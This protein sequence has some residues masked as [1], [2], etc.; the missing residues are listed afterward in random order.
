[1]KTEVTMLPNTSRA[2]M[3]PAAHP[4][5]DAEPRIAPASVRLRRLHARTST[6]VSAELFE[7]HV[8]DR[9]LAELPSDTMRLLIVL[10]EVV[11]RA[12]LRTSPGQEIPTDYPGPNHISLVP[13]GLRAWPRVERMGYCRHWLVH[14]DADRL[15]SGKLERPEFLPRLMLSDATIWRYG[16]PIAEECARPGALSDAYGESLS[17][18]FFLYL[19]RLNGDSARETYQSRL[20]PLQLR[21]VTNFM[22]AHLAETPQVSELAAISG[23][24]RGHF[25]RAFK[26]STGL[27]P[28]RWHLNMRTHRARMLLADASLSLAEVAYA[29]GFAD[30][31]HFTRTFSRIVGMSP[32]AWRRGQ[33]AWADIDEASQAPICE[34]AIRNDAIGIEIHP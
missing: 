16:Q 5:N 24:S 20:A 25:S 33:K 32:G 9:N 31:S 7:M 29:T 21:K 34:L 18:A 10:S 3:P 22:C 27:P 19:V 6:G 2:T 1:M 11:G 15:W 23:L 26:G 17:L 30:Q 28:Q 13:E 8:A 12:E 14:F 4:A